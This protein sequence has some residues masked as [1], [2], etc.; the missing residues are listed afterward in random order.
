MDLLWHS[1]LLKRV[2][3]RHRPLH[4]GAARTAQPLAFDRRPGNRMSGMTPLTSVS[5]E[6]VEPL[7]GSGPHLWRDPRNPSCKKRE[8]QQRMN[9][10]SAGS[11]ASRWSRPDECRNLTQC[12]VPTT[13]RS[14]SARRHAGALQPLHIYC[15]NLFKIPPTIFKI[16]ENRFIPP[17]PH[18]FGHCFRPSNIWSGNT[19]APR[20]KCGAFHS[21]SILLGVSLRAIWGGRD[22]R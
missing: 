4:V 17:P 13:S 6:E 10:R 21:V 22:G 9:W 12:P 7:L 20:T 11:G 18:H 2:P 1:F 16:S 15:R 3:S 19:M 8:T 5:Q 14:S